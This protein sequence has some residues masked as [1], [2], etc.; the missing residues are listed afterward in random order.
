MPSEE[1]TKTFAHSPVTAIGAEGSRTPNLSI[2]KAGANLTFYLGTHEQVWLER[3]DIPLCGQTRY[4]T[5]RGVRHEHCAA[6]AVLPP[7]HH[8]ELHCLR[9]RREPGAAGRGPAPSRRPILHTKGVR[10]SAGRR[11]ADS[12]IDWSRRAH[13]RPRLLC[14]IMC[15]SLGV[16]PTNPPRLSRTASFNSQNENATRMS[17]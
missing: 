7:L 1:T 15:H 13:C 10:G 4:H 12:A 14:G 17:R 2:A 5:M 6:N 16:S 3:V 9:A 8:S 11:L